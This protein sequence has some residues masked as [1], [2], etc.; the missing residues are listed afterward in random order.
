MDRN[1]EKQKGKKK[2]HRASPPQKNPAFRKRRQV[3]N[4]C[5]HKHFILGGGL[6]GLLPDSILE[7]VGDSMC[8]S[9]DRYTY[10]V[11]VPNI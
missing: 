1:E 10:T 2:T 4:K 8:S 3:G 5:A 9:A 7:G 6:F 11:S